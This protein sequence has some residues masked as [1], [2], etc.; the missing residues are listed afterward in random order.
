MSITYVNSSFAEKCQSRYIKMT[1]V[2]LLAQRMVVRF[3]ALNDTDDADADLVQR[4]LGEPYLA[5]NLTLQNL[6]IP[7]S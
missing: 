6:W 1:I 3:P 5:R 4:I 2:H 7:I